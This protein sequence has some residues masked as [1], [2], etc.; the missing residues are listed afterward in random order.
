MQA[1]ST[2]DTLNCAQRTA[3][4]FGERSAGNEF[5]AGPLL[6]IAGAVGY[7]GVQELAGPS[8]RARRL[9]PVL[10][11]LALYTCFTNVSMTLSQPRF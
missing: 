4:H 9:V 6:I 10:I 7:Q 1:I 11:A 2:L 8:R 3:A 5:R